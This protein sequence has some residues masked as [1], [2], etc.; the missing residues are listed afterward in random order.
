MNYAVV[1]SSRT[2]NTKQ[3]ANV[4]QEVLRETNM[5]DVREEGKEVQNADILFVGF[6]TDKGTCSEEMKEFLNTLEGKKIF[7]FGTAGFGQSQTYFDQIIERVKKEI[8][9]S[10]QVIGSYMCQGKM[11]ITVRERYIKLQ[12]E[13][14]TNKQ[15]EK[16]IQNF[17]T[18]LS[19]PDQQ[20]LEGIRKKVL[21]IVKE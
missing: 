19:H 6:W 14:P 7:L 1:T 4:I 3:L 17:D 10:N 13:D 18:A 21:E 2:G 11:P 15:Y 9:Q 12:K 5:I 16:L 20:D 8:P